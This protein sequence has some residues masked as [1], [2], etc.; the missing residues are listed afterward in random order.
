MSSSQ[1][2]AKVK[3]T[4]L[5]VAPSPLRTYGARYSPSVLLFLLVIGAPNLTKRLS[6]LLIWKL[7]RQMLFGLQ[8]L[9]IPFSAYSLIFS[10]TLIMTKL[11]I[12]SLS[13]AFFMSINSFI[14]IEVLNV[15]DSDV[16]L[17]LEDEL[18]T[19]SP[20]SCFV[21][22]PRTPDLLILPLPLSTSLLRC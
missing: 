12:E 21:C 19:S 8:L 20:S 16:A 17:I 1:M 9:M 5:S 3:T 14:V 10:R 2:T 7:L 22:S 15:L 13:S 11:I 6:M 18:R 4:D